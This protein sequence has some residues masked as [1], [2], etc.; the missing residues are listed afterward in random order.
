MH[1]KGRIAI[2]IFLKVF[3]SKK[4]IS[5]KIKIKKKKKISY[6]LQQNHLRSGFVE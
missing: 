6:S 2:E 5:S 4:L 3:C 1:S